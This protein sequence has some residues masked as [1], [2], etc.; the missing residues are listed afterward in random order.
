[1]LKLLVIKNDVLKQWQRSY[2]KE[3]F[4][5][6]INRMLKSC[7][8]TQSEVGWGGV[9]MVVVMVC[10]CCDVYVGVLVVLLCKDKKTV[11]LLFLEESHC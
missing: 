10:S 5:V 6:A 11:V 4:E 1:M 2:S 8:K 3:L 9:L 7:I